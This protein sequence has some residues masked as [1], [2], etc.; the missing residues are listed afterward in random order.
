MIFHMKNDAQFLLLKLKEKNLM[1]GK[2][3][4][5]T[6]ITLFRDITVSHGSV[7]VSK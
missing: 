2:G 6:A 3:I 7:E 4:Q 1:W 5:C